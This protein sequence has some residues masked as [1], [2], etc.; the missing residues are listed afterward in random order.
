[1][2]EKGFTLER[3]P[4]H[5][6]FQFEDTSRET[7]VFEIDLPKEYV[8]DDVPDPVSVD[9]GFAMYQSKVEVWDRSCDTLANSYGGTY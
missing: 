6:P 3:K 7:D 9:M 5:F 2:G 8:V 4:R 1:M